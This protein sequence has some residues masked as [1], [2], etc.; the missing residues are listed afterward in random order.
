MEDYSAP[1]GGS[2]GG[3][4]G[5]RPRDDYEYDRGGRG[6]YGYQGRGGRGGYGGDRRDDYPPRRSYDGGDR[7]SRGRRVDPASPEDGEDFS[8]R[9]ND[10]M[11][12]LG[13]AKAV[14]DISR[15]T[16]KAWEG[17]LILKNSLF[18]SKLHLVE[19]SSRLADQLKD[20]NGLPN[21]K[22]T[23]RLRLDQSKLDDV[24]RRMNTSTSHAIFLCEVASAINAN[25]WHSLPV[26]AVV[27]MAIRGS[28][29]FSA[30][31]IPQ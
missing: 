4:G 16:S 21:L 3:G 30:L 26:P 8:P 5:G 19:G 1:G 12:G 28:M 29:G 6:R 24:N 25:D 13:D 9:D 10:R 15:L 11:Q 31:P 23:Q 17:G 7:M 2:G 27:G 14:T 20:E 22:I 18:P